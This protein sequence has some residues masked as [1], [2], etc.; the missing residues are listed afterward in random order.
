MKRI[1]SI[2]LLL[3]TFYGCTNDSDT[4]PVAANTIDNIIKSV[5]PA[6]WYKNHRAA[7]SLNYDASVG[8]VTRVLWATDA[9]IEKGVNLDLEFVT[10][11]YDEPEN[12][13][14]LDYIRDYLI[15]NGIGFFGHGHEHVNH[16]ELTYQEAY[17]SFKLCY[18]LMK[19]WNIPTI[20]YAYP[21]SRGYYY[22]TQL[23][24]E[25]AGFIAARGVAQTEDSYYLCLNEDSEPDNWFYLPSVP[26]G[27][28]GATTIHNHERSA[29][30]ITKALELKSWTILM[31]HSIG[32]PESYSYYPLEDFKQ[33]L[34]LINS[35]DFWCAHQ[36]DVIRYLK[37]RLNFTY[38][39]DNISRQDN[40]TELN[41]KFD[42]GLDNSIFNQPLTVTIE[43]NDFD[44]FTKCKFKP[45][46]NET[47]EYNIINN[48]ISLE[49]IPDEISRKLILLK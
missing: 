10:A 48:N 25:K 28:S 21:G 31:Y 6:K 4:N 40:K 8:N 20:S 5:K 32:L 3:V 39:I 13:H 26:Y 19:M 45:A 7:I 22:S 49:I 38:S 12:Q 33:D 17:N 1:I 23:A 35:L 14:Y 42:D 30:V 37:E 46:I 9:A 18:D 34:D 36:D 2:I 15:P 11:K 43:L 44:S 24:C 27:N 29:E 41:I 47:N 16:D